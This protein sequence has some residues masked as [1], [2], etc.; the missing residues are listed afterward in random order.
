MYTTYISFKNIANL[1][2]Y[3]K[4]ELTCPENKYFTVDGEA[5]PSLS[6]F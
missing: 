5:L 2:T 6:R 4:N 1:L 3:P